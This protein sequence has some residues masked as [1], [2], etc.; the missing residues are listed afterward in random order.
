MLP[1]WLTVAGLITEKFLYIYRLSSTTCFQE[2][3]AGQPEDE[4]EDYRG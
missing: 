3:P 2:A 1:R 4:A